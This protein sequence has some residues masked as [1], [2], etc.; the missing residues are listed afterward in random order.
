MYESHYVR[1]GSAYSEHEAIAER[2][3]APPRTMHKVRTSTVFVCPAALTVLA[4]S[5]LIDHYFTLPLLHLLGF[6]YMESFIQHWS[7]YHAHV[8]C[9]DSVFQPFPLPV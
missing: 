4:V 7:K 5:V 9:F 6:V 1:Q 3:A 2:N 8:G